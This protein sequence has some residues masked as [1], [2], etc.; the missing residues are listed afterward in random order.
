MYLLSNLYILLPFQKFTSVKEN[1]ISQ[2]HFQSG[3]HP[4]GENSK[5]QMKV[6]SPIAN[7]M[8]PVHIVRQKF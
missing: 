5:K 8:T 1:M 6:N 7:I 4:L 3:R 2:C